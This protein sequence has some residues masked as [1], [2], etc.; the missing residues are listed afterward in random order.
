MN[1]DLKHPTNTQLL[2]GMVVALLSG[3]G[4]VAIWDHLTLDAKH[5]IRIT[6]VEGSIEELKGKIINLEA[7]LPHGH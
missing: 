3:G 6:N 1:I 7:K 2:V 4:G 5:E